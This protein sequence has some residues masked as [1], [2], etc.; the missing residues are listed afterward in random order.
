MRTALRFHCRAFVAQP[1]VQ[2]LIRREWNG[3]LLND[4]LDTQQGQSTQRARSP[5]PRS[6]ARPLKKS[7]SKH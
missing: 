6:R 7:W 2:A 3:K 1:E 5:T 4:V